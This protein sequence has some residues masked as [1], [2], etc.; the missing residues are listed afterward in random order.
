MEQWVDSFA[1]KK[2][3]YFTEKLKTPHFTGLPWKNRFIWAYPA[4]KNLVWP[5]LSGMHIKEDATPQRR[6]RDKGKGYSHLRKNPKLSLSGYSWVLAE[7]S[8]KRGAVGAGMLLCICD[9]S[10][11][12]YNPS[13][14]LEYEA[15]D[16]LPFIPRQYSFKSCRLADLCFQ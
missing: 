8:W 3:L 4:S 16:Y 1:G 6:Y 9:K 15:K 10:E 2:R 11:P 5:K 12:T 14:P 13:H 7:E